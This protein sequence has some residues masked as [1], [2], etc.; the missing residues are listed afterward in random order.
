MTS[1]PACH[2]GGVCAV[3][4]IHCSPP[5][6]QRLFQ[7]PHTGLKIC[8]VLLDVVRHRHCDRLVAQE[9]RVRA[10]TTA[11]VGTLRLVIVEL[12]S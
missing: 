9:L 3:L 12:S 6:L 11:V 4:E 1:Y 5:Q 7:A 10:G 2:N 8:F